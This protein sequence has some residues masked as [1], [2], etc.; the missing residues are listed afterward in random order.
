MSSQGLPSLGSADGQDDSRRC[1]KQCY[2]MNYI[3]FFD[4]TMLDAR[5]ISFD[6]LLNYIA[7]REIRNCTKIAS[8]ELVF[9]YVRFSVFVNR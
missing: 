5:S 6:L 1:R 4:G 3:V 9:V 2:K 8:D 7:I